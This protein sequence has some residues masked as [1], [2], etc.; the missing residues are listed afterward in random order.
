MG[1]NWLER[2]KKQTM[3]NEINIPE[4]K[5]SITKQRAQQHVATLNCHTI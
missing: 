2:S 3:F 5:K 4:P 1:E